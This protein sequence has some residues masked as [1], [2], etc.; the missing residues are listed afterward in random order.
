MKIPNRIAEPFHRAVNKG[1]HEIEPVNE[2]K[3]PRASEAKRVGCYALLG[4][5]PSLHI[6]WQSPRRSP[7]SARYPAGQCI[8]RRGP[9]RESLLAPR[10]AQRQ[11]TL[12]RRSCRSVPL[13]LVNGGCV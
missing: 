3:V 12:L 11:E 9:R 8:V 13:P 6:V 2:Q 7:F 5:G 1:G 10:S 4:A